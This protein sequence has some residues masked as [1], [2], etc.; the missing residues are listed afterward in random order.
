MFHGDFI[1]R[2]TVFK[3]YKELSFQHVG[4]P[5]DEEAAEDY[6]KSFTWD[7]NTLVEES[8]QK[9]VKIYLPKYAC[10]FLDPHTPSSEPCSL[11]F[12]VTDDGFITGIPYQGLLTKEHFL[13]P[14][15]IAELSKKIRLKGRSDDM[16]NH[17]LDF[18][19][20]DVIKVDYVEQQLPSSHPHLETYLQKKKVLNEKI[21]QHSKRYMKWQEKNDLYSG[22][23]VD[24]YE[25]QVSR[26]EF[27]VYLRKNRKYDIIDRIRRGETIEQQRFDKI[28]EFRESGDNIYYW[29]CLWKDEILEKI[30]KKK[31]IREKVYKNILSRLETIYSPT[32]ILFK[33]GDLVPWWM[34]NKKNE[35]MML[36]LVRFVVR[37][38]KRDDISS[39]QFM[40]YTHQRW[41]KCYRTIVGDQPC[42]LP[43]S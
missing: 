24:I 3:E 35:G 41:M 2:E 33:A 17:I 8:L 12:G 29:L 9:Y 21:E 15:V 4:I 19:D 31:P 26:K 7:F 20:V 28:R 16:E 43:Y 40:D 22:K 14:E 36:Y 32:H 27:L 30:R 13:T 1:G 18:I 5:F 34:Q 42:C 10:A 23:L 6:V 38:E 39:I 25:N 37:T 11:T